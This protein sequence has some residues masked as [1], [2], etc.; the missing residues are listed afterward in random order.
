VLSLEEL[1]E[2]P[3]AKR[4]EAET[5]RYKHLMYLKK[6]ENQKESL[7]CIKGSA[8]EMSSKITF[9]SSSEK[10][11]KSQCVSEQEEKRIKWKIN[12]SRNRKRKQ[13]EDE[14]GY[15]KSRALERAR[16]R[17]KAKDIDLVAYNKSRARERV[18]EREKA[19]EKNKTMEWRNKKFR[20]SVRYGRIYNC[21]CCER[22]CFKNGVT[23]YTRSFQ[24]SIDSKFE[25]MT[26]RAI[27]GNYSFDED[28][29]YIC[30]TCKHH[31]QKGKVP[32]MSRQ[33]ALKLMDLRGYEELQVTELENSMIALNI[34]FQKVFKLPKSRWPGM[35]DKT[36][37]IPIYESDIINTVKSL[38]RTPTSAGIIPINL[39]RKLGYKNSHMVQ[40]ISVEKIMKALQTLK[41]L[42]N[43][44]YQFIPLSSDFIDECR[45]IDLEGFNFLFA[46][47]EILTSNEIRADEESLEKLN[48]TNK[49]YDKEEMAN[50]DKREMACNV[51][52]FDL[53]MHMT[54]GSSAE[55]MVSE[56]QDDVQDEVE[57]EELEYEKK[58]SVKKWQFPYNIS[59]CFSNNYP[60]ISYK[61][62]SERVS[63]APGEGKSPSNI[64]EE[65][66]WDL[67][68]FPCLLP[69]GKN[70][71]HSHK[72][73]KLSDQDYFVQRILNKDLRFATTPA[74]VFA[75]VAYLEKKQ[76]QSRIGLSFKRG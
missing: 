56:L 64:L 11:N 45:E 52:K 35:K 69:D 2:I 9:L 48:S 14:S 29:S 50:Y 28:V 32:P 39:K 37:N 40:Y 53:S 54:A 24:E 46:E 44:Y 75:A 59:T 62:D 51:E 49:N 19:K 21:V 15:N 68:S 8:N 27:G 34:I 76:I 66:D 4:N 67:K 60:E 41:E 30:S 71:L 26:S 31:I 74:Y 58:D 20:E 73:I 65:K 3:V 72:T 47:D 18:K 1:K 7:I 57:K 12:K 43:K 63:V 10:L 16:E 22:L 55:Q 70:S 17:K 38:P 13:E 5:K 25:N 6:K 33:N 42:G 61:D 23:L 36:I